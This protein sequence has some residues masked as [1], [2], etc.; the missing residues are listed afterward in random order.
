MSEQTRP[1]IDAG[2]GEAVDPGAE[3]D[4]RSATETARAD[5]YEQHGGFPKITPA[6]VGPEFGDFVEAM[7][8]LQDLSV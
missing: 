4:S 7:R 2:S 8:T 1:M 5:R 3:V 6:Q